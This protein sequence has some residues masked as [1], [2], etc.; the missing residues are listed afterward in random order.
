MLKI[1]ECGYEDVYDFTVP[2][3]SNFYINDILVHNC[4]EIVLRSCQFC[5]LTEVVIRPEDT[6][7]TL[8]AK[9]ELATILGT[10]QSTLTDFRYLRSVWRKNTE[11]ERLLGVSLT[12]IM[13][14]PVM[15]GKG[16]KEELKTWLT[17]LRA[18]AIE[19]NDK[20][21]DTLGIEQSVA[22]ST[23]KPSGCTT[24]E[25]K[26]KT[27]AGVKSMATLFA[28]NYDGNIF[29]LS[30]DTWIEPK[31]DIIVYDENNDLQK[32]TK[33]Y[34][35]GISDVYEIEDEYGNTYKFTGN[36]KLK[37]SN[38]GWVRVDELTVEDDIVSY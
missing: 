8:L 14:H 6:L 9:V 12:G 37:T 7:D 30:P 18:K 24:L 3:T 19:V 20:W 27:T 28:E 31:N 33:L 32:V 1:E 36:H 2:D 16:D 10:F 25:T 34:I 13:D 17:A 35:N 21:A 23:L 29:E 22:L 15:S 11:E 38:R 5:N 26:V 4:G